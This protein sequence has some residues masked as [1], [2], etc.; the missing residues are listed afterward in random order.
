[1]GLQRPVAE[2]RD[3]VS[4]LL[5]ELCDR[6]EQVSLQQALGR[7]LMTDVRSPIALPGFDNSQMDGYA[8]RAAE[9]AAATDAV[10]AELAVGETI[11]AG[12]TDT[13]PLP[14]GTA[15]PIMTGA[16]IPTGADAVIA[17]EAAKPDRFL[18]VRPARV[19]F[20][21]PVQPG[22]FLR[23]QGSDVASDQLLVRAGQPLG[24]R[25][26]GLLAATGVA[27]VWVRPRPRVLLLST[28]SELRQPGEPLEPGQIYDAN[29][30]MLAA[31]LTEDGADVATAAITPD[32]ATEFN[33]TLGDRLRQAP[34][35]F[36]LIVTSGGVCA[37]AFEVVKEAVAGDAE[38]VGVAMQPGGPQGLGRFAGIPLLAFPGNPVS[39]FVSY[40]VFLRPV[41]RAAAGCPVVGRPNVPARLDQPLTSPADKHQLRRG[42]LRT[43]PTGYIV[44]LNSGPGSHLLGSLAQSNALVHVPVG[45]DRLPAGA[46]VDVWQLDEPLSPPSRPERSESTS[47]SHLSRG[48]EAHMVD[49]SKKT[50]GKR[51]ASARALVRTTAEVVTELE[52]ANLKKGD[53]LGVARVAGIM[54]GKRT[55][56]LVPLCHPLPLTG[57]SVELATGHDSVEIT[58]TVATT[59]VTGVEMEALTAASGAGPTVYDMIKAID[60]AATIEQ[61]AVWRKTGGKTGEWVRP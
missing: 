46:V 44:D 4:A 34:E 5:R 43:T 51:E 33:T 9:L 16:P 26:L 57:V 41:L 27:T 38:F 52:T 12:R 7:I 30:T 61:V 24:V 10:P 55:A 54:P 8:V 47:L 28:G 35:P 58:A 25:Q 39:A 40:E 45:I 18:T 31:A 3:A 60:P 56:E 50:P 19:S 6:T 1:M 32:S 36:D 21:A 11:P 37:G 49:V 53:A 23:R 42:T 14:P 17:I 29:T 48:G 22:T 59:A 20:R 2:H 15:M 13:P